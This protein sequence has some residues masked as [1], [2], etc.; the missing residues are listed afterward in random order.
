MTTP[1]LTKWLRDNSSGVY[2]PA[3]E[4]ADLIEA[5][6]KQNAEL[7]RELTNEQ[8]N[9]YA[10]ASQHL[11]ENLLRLTSS[12]LRDF[13]NRLLLRSPLVWIKDMWRDS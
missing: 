7:K 3:A 8:K 6:V 2:R 10:L 13:I 1:E 12:P 9:Y 5:L 4:A 11:H